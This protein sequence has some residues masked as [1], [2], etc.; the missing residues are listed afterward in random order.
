MFSATYLKD[1]INLL[2]S[3]KHCFALANYVAKCKEF[4]TS[5]DPS[6]GWGFSRFVLISSVYIRT[7]NFR[8]PVLGG[9]KMGLADQGE[10]FLRRHQ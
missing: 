6:Q 10:S 4:A 9:K 7:E 5:Q 2:K 8:R 3:C 1:V